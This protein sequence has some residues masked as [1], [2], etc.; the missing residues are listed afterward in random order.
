MLNRYI[1]FTEKRMVSNHINNHHY[2]VAYTL[3]NLSK[4]NHTDY[5]RNK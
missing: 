2:K 1:P 5:R 3:Q 4:K